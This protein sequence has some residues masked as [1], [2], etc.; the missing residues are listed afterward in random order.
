MKQLLNKYSDFI[1]G[2]NKHQQEK[3]DFGF[4]Q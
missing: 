1:D 3:Q 2:S 4:Q